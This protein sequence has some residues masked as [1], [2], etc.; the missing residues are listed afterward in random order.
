MRISEPFK[1]PSGESG[2]DLWPAFRALDGIP[3]LVVHGEISDLLTAETVEAMKAE[4]PS[5]ESITVPRVGHAPTLDE[6]EAAAAIEALLKR[7]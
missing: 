6:P 2:F 4:V 3:S 1:L 7:V 5:M